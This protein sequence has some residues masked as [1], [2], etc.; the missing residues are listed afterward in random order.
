MNRIPSLAISIII[1]ALVSTLILGPQQFRHPSPTSSISSTTPS[2]KSPHR[3]ATPPVVFLMQPFV[4]GDCVSING[5]MNPTTPRATLGPASWSWGDGSISTS[6]FPATHVYTSTGIYLVQVTATD[7]SG[8]KATTSRTVNVTGSTELVPPQLTVFNPAIAG[9]MVTINGVANSNA[10]QSELQ[11]FSF[12]WGDDTVSTGWLFQ[13]HTYNSRGNFQV[14]V[15]ATDS[16]GAA[17]TK[18]ELASVQ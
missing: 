3:H 9:R 13:S 10:C 14:C 7:S 5:A 8:L 6:W 11:P 18:C 12:N 16:F 4:Y 15:T 17:T 1:I 2:T